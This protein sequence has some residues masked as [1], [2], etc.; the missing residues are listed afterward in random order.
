MSLLVL[1]RECGGQV[2]RGHE[3]RNQLTIVV[4]RRSILVTVGELGLEVGR[5]AGTPVLVGLP[6]DGRGKVYLVKTL[7][8]TLEAAT[9]GRVV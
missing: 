7:A 4:A 1:E 5:K 9:V 6:A 8:V 2:G 3:S